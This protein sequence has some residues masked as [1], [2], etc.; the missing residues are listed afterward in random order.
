[1]NI[2]AVGRGVVVNEGINRDS[3]DE[4]KG[5][6]KASGASEWLEEVLA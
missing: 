2:A 5:D 4:I 1:M 6:A 3:K